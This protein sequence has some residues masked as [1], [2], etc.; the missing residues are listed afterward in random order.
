MAAAKSALAG[1]YAARPIEDNLREIEM[2]LLPRN[3]PV[4]VSGMI[5]KITAADV[6]RVAKRLFDAN[7]LT[8]VV[9]GKVNEAFNSGKSGL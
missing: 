9:V 1:E 6:Q 4:E 8:V 7:A 3:F 5:G 2:Y